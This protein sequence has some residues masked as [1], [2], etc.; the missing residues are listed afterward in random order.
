M[1]VDTIPMFQDNYA[2]LVICEQD[3]AGA[4]VDPAE[5][6]PVLAR[7]DARGVALRWIWNTHHHFDHVAGNSQ[8]QQAHGGSRIVAHSRDQSRIEDVASAV[9]DGD[10]VELG[11]AGRFTRDPGRPGAPPGVSPLGGVDVRGEERGRHLDKIQTGSPVRPAT[12]CGDCGRI[13]CSQIVFDL[14]RRV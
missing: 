7:I 12:A 8:V 4:V 2:Y 11:Q 10:A 14:A 9:D 6:G 13:D 5:P 3:D 1:I